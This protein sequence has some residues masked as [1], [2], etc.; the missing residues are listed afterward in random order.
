MSSE[1]DLVINPDDEQRWIEWAHLALT[2]EGV[3]SAL[4]VLGAYLALHPSR[5]DEL[6]AEWEATHADSGQR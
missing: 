4:Q 2:Y 1:T 3:D 5:S 6:A